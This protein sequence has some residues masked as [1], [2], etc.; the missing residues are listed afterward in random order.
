MSELLSTMRLKVCTKRDTRR[1]RY[2]RF[3]ISKSLDRKFVSSRRCRI[4]FRGN[5][6][7]REFCNESI[8][9][10]G[11]SQ[12]GMLG[13]FL[14]APIMRLSSALRLM[15]NWW[16]E[17]SHSSSLEISLDVMSSLKNFYLLKNDICFKEFYKFCIRIN[18]H[19]IISTIKFIC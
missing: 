9:T 3:L 13:L 7:D 14:S 12:S 18:F 16:M 19:F 4:R 17:D 2:L 11:R 5:F 8:I 15:I 1:K 6:S 10:T